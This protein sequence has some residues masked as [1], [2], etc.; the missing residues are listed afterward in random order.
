ML[1]WYE[2]LNNDTRLVLELGS[3]FP[4]QYLAVP[5]IGYFK[6]LSYQ[7]GTSIRHVYNT[8]I[9]HVYNISC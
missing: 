2:L 3:F 7:C 4:P 1:D 6:K 8:S 5:G 9:R